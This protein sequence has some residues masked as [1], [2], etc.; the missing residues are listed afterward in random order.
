VG[1][2]QY[3][4]R[5]G[6]RIIQFFLHMSEDEQRKRFLDRIDK[7][8]KTWK[9]SEADMERKFWN[10]Y[11]RA[12]EAC[13]SATSTKTAPS[14][15]EPVD[16]EENAR[17]I[18]SQIVISTFKSLKMQYPE[19]AGHHCCALRCRRNWLNT[20]LATELYL[21]SQNID[22]VPTPAADA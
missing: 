21:P 18:I 10:E 2:E 19:S 14:Y 16:D 17:L 9:F 13:L 12:Y 6:R 20:R 8:E 3:L 5:S 15:V 11:M 22:A 1:S 7:P 4:Y